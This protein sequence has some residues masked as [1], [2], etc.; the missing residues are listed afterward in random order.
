[1]LQQ[2]Y[3]AKTKGGLTKPGA[4]M[5]TVAKSKGISSAFATGV[6]HKYCEY[7]PPLR[8]S[9]YLDEN[10][11]QYP[12]S[13]TVVRVDSGEMIVGRTVFV[14]TDVMGESSFFTHNFVI[15]VAY[16]SEYI[17]E[18]K[19]LLY[20]SNF[21]GADVDLVQTNLSE[22][23]SLQ[24]EPGR[25][26]LGD[27]DQ[28]L[29]HY[30]IDE[31]LYKAMLLAAI[32]AI[33]RNGRIYIIPNVK[34][35]KLLGAA[36]DIMKF[37]IVSLPHDYRKK[38]G[39]T[40]YAKSNLNREN[41]HIYFLEKD[42]TGYLISAQLNGRVFDFAN[43]IFTKPDTKTP[44]YAD[45]AWNNKCNDRRAFYD[46]LNSASPKRQADIDLLNEMCVFWQ[47]RDSDD[48]DIYLKNRV[49]ILSAMIKGHNSGTAEL[50]S[51]F[52]GI[53]E[54]I[55]EREE[56]DR[57]NNADYFPEKDVV[58]LILGYSEIIKNNDIDTKALNLAA[59]CLYDAVSKKNA[60]YINGVLSS[61]SGYKRMFRK[62]LRLFEENRRAETDSMVISY[63]S[64]R[65]G[66]ISSVQELVD[67]VELWWTNSIGVFNDGVIASCFVDK[68]REIFLA[69]PD[70]VEAGAQFH[71]RMEYMLRNSERKENKKGFYD[72]CRSMLEAV[73]GVVI[74]SISLET[75]TQDM[76]K[77]LKV[78]SEALRSGEKY[79]TF[80]SLKGFVCSDSKFVI[81]KSLKDLR[82][83]SN[84]SYSKVFMALKRI[85]A[86]G[87]REEN[88]DKI[89]MVFDDN[90]RKD[91]IKDLIK[92]LFEYITE[93]R[94]RAE[95]CNYI[96]W[97]YRNG[98]FVEN[99]TEFNQVVV[100]FFDK[101]T[102][103]EFKVVQKNY[104]YLY[105][106]GNLSEGE[107]NLKFIIETITKKNSIIPKAATAHESFRNIAVL[108]LIGLSI[109]AAIG[110]LL[111]FVST[112]LG[113]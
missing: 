38:L 79:R 3:Y 113:D 81:E 105:S 96:R 6:L 55:L 44:L 90:E 89:T 109:V 32:E 107:K 83:K 35:G 97:A 88:Y 62:L 77:A 50:K 52:V 108:L 57:R 20:V 69:L 13:L 9:H 22:V 68:A 42:Y 12:E 82:E 41:I 30:G 54:K 56:R 17:P 26:E 102:P 28:T 23:A 7:E 8:L 33:E 4:G 84:A 99:Y 104:N 67:E 111:L 47:L 29:L 70:K 106:S 87:I 36:Q 76:L 40:T 80:E 103:K 71:T 73:D 14:P 60:D 61:I 49:Y 48:M 74:D 11:D 51:T 94:N 63:I 65:V 37:I 86:P 98:A 53:F 91:L 2:H 112:I 24:F 27:C 64:S 59:D 45:Y 5:D 95:T 85:L 1:M 18:Y 21:S 31:E 15:P 66:E 100:D 75:V 39:F 43:S 58:A 46:F 72:L 110:L 101:F 92:E 34:T 25:A 78:D 16:I 19:N 10:K 93:N